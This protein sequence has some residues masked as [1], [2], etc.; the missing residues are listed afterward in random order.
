MSLVAVLPGGQ[1]RGS[2]QDGRPKTLPPMPGIRNDVFDQPVRPPAVGQVRDDDEDA[3]GYN[4]AVL[5]RYNDV[6]VFIRQNRAP[7]LCRAGI[8][9]RQCVLPEL[10]IQ[11]QEPAKIAFGGFT[12]RHH[13]S[14]ALSGQASAFLMQ[15]DSG[16][17]I[18][19]P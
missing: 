8:V 19:G 2:V 17:L 18:Y 1:R 15:S 12:D 4:S 11:P 3:G 9:L 16:M 10:G 5:F 14:P 6:M 13:G 7:G